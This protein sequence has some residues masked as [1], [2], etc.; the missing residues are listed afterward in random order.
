[1]HTLAAVQFCE[2]VIGHERVGKFAALLVDDLGIGDG[3]ADGL[4]D[5]DGVLGGRSAVVIAVMDGGVVGVGAYDGYLLDILGERKDAIVLQEYHCLTRCL[6]GEGCMLGAADVRGSEICPGR[7]LLGIE[8]AELDAAAQDAP[9]GAVEVGLRDETLLHALEQGPVTGAALEVGAGEDGVC[10]GGGGVGMGLV[11]AAGV[12]VVDGAA[13]GEDDV[14][15][16]PLL[17][18][19]L[20]QEA[21]AAAAG[22]TLVAVVGAHDL[23]DA[24]ILDDGAESR[25]VGLPKVAHRHGGV[26]AVA[27]ALRAAVDGVVL[28]ACMCLVAFSVKCL[29]CADGSAAHNAGEVRVLAAGLLAASPPRVA[30]D[31]DVGAP[32]GKADVPDASGSLRLPEDVVVGGVPGG[33]GFV[34]D[35]SVDLELL[36]LVE[37]GGKSDGLREDGGAGTADAVAGLGP[38]VVGGNAEPVD[39]HGSVH[40]Q[41]D[42]LLRGKEGDEILN[43]LLDG[44]FG[45]LEG[46][47]VLV[48]VAGCHHQASGCKNQK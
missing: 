14:V 38:P 37:C 27:L 35:G 7:I 31:V 16:T 19:D 39:G 22:I 1:M 18:E 21:V 24:G 48:P 13:V 44:Q 10:T 45:V 26:E 9:E 3:P 33:A 23:L 8:G 34:G 2:F 11:L 43:P 41:A 12:E 36:G 4:E 20:G 47:L 5:G 28:D 6:P 46:I 30:E 25:E 15:I 32:E 40:H 29:H 42:F 17:A